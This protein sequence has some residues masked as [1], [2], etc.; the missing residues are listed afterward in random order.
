M[1][2]AQ[3]FGND[4]LKRTADCFCLRETENAAGTPVPHPDHALGVCIDEGI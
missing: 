4:D 1:P 2:L 3:I